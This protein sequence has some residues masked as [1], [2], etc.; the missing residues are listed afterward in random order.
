M[1]KKAAATAVEQSD[2]IALIDKQVSEL[3]GLRKSNPQSF[4]SRQGRPDQCG[5]NHLRTEELL[6]RLKGFA[7]RLEKLR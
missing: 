2:P 5:S 7:V 1:A 4:Y 3:E 6:G